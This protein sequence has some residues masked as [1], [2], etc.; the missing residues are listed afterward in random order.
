MVLPWVC[1][2][3]EQCPIYITNTWGFKKRKS[4]I[5]HCIYLRSSYS[6]WSW[7]PHSPPGPHN[8][9]DHQLESRVMSNSLIHSTVSWPVLLINLNRQIM[10][11]YIRSSLIWTPC[12]SMQEPPQRQDI[13]G[14]PFGF[15]TN[16]HLLITC[17]KNKQINNQ[18]SIRQVHLSQL[19]FP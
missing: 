15:Q 7:G 8:A 10:Y 19:H 5:F 13:M 12:D 4:N 16:R 6:T 11:G 18:N 1:V 2:T 17:L 14:N 3:R 9:R